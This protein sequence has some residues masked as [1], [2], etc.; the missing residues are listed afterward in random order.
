MSKPQK[1]KKIILKKKKPTIKFSYPGSITITFGDVAENHVGMQKLGKLAS[2]GFSKKDLLE[3]QEIFNKQGINTE[4]ID[5]I[6]ESG[7]DQSTL[8]RPLESA[9]LLIVRNVTTFLLN[10]KHN[11]YDLL[12]EQAK[13]NVDKKA[14]MRGRVVNKR[15]RYNVCFSN[16]SQEPDYEEKKGRIIA[17]DE[18]PLLKTIQEKLHK[19]IGNKSKNLEAEGN[20][21]FDSDKCG[22]GYHGDAERRIVVAFRLG[23]T[24]QLCYQ[25]YHRF[26][27]IGDNM[28]FKLKHGDMYIM[29]DKATGYDWRK[30]SQYTL[31]HAAGCSK[32]T[33][34][35]HK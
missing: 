6:Q 30:S 17:Y 3:T 22:I 25:W 35:K 8:D 12:T 20:Y 4:M 28:S 32:Y 9:Y 7:I 26:N 29:S 31:R 11:S 34:V 19:F 21:Y 5:L 16:S 18:V 2:C 10:G 33:T 1:K 13:L 23:K 27:P 15:A 24:I 14:Y